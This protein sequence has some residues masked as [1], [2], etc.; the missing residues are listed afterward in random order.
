M[1]QV[2]QTLKRSLSDRALLSPQLASPSPPAAVVLSPSQD[3][4]ERI[5]R[6]EPAVGVA[7]GGGGGIR[8]VGGGGNISPARPEGGVPLGGEGKVGQIAKK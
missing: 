3:E 7:G 6:R 1:N 2:N 5:G 8:V 4:D